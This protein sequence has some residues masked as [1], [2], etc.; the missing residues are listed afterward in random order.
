MATNV[1][2]RNDRGFALLGW[3]GIGDMIVCTPA[4]KALKLA[5][6]DA[7]IHFYGSGLHKQ[8]LLHNPFIDRIV[9]VP[10]WKL[11]NAYEKYARIVGRT[12]CRL[13]FQRISPGFLDDRSVVDMAAEH[14]G[15]TITDRKIQIKLTAEEIV[16]AEQRLSGLKKPVIL[17]HAHSRSSQHHMWFH[18]RWDQLVNSLPEYDF[19]QVG[20]G[21]E[22]PIKGATHLL[23][24]TSLREAFAL[25]SRATSFVGV[26]SS[27]NHAS[28]AFGVPGVVLFGDSSPVYW[29]HANNTNIYVHKE[30]S[31]CFYVLLGRHCV[32][33]RH[34]MRSITVENVRDAL[35]SQI[36]R[37]RNLL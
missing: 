18:E 24:S 1:K 17:I 12:T 32:Y 3:G 11:Y 21:D 9:T 19:V 25:L 36:S 15:V 13:N 35:I 29:G 20:W 7:S 4:I 28:N 30:C 2:V 6:P 16:G 8:A 5:N 23:G 31:P 26:N 34:C 37:A 10:H 33:D 14:L 22:V 27:M